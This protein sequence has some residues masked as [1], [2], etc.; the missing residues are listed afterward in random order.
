VL[1]HWR[2]S[3]YNEKWVISATGTAAQ[4]VTVTGVPG[5]AGELPVIDGR[6]ATTRL[7]LNYWSEE[8]G[9]VNVG[10]SNLAPGS[11]SHVVIENLDI[12]SARPPYGFTDEAGN[13]DLYSKNA[14]AIYLVEGSHIAIRNCVLRDC[15]NGLFASHGARD[16][17]VEGCHVYDNGIESSIYEH[18][19]YTEAERI[20]FQ[21]NH[22]GPLRT[23]CLGNNLKDRSTGLVVR[24]NW[25]EAGNRQLDLVD[26][27]HFVGHPDYGET[28]VY[29]NVLVE[30]DGEGNRQIVHFGGDSGTAS[31]YR[32]TLYFHNNTVV[33]T[34]SG[35]T[36]LFR[37]SENAQSCD[38]RNN[39]IYVAAQGSELE[40][41][42]QKGQLALRA[43]YLKPGW[44]TSF[45]G[46][47]PGASV[48]VAE[49]NVEAAS[50][51]FAD[52]PGQDY[53]LAAG[54]V[55]VNAGTALAAACLPDHGVTRE[56]VKHAAS[57]PRPAAGALDIGA[58]EYAARATRDDVD[59][60]LRDFGSGAAGADEASVRLTVRSY[61]EQ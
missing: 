23:N 32:G 36:T 52:E 54:S 38:C 31:R 57:R 35:R 13:A 33:S 16:V 60:A 34:R 44:V 11:G 1:I 53:S 2:T 37:L 14:A 51:G 29:G 17:L 61:R 25:I 19:S 48:T 6:N 15:G 30:H 50:P 9:I 41:L 26:T 7:A 4:P 55:C 49:A 56:Y 43:N 45:G 27:V 10:G 46:L 42:S 47:D 24:Y 20:T 8:R 12:R 5:P 22:Y 21:W 59:A 58:Y 28:F 39:V 40:L 18:N 3:P